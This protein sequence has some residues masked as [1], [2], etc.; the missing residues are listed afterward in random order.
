MS[1]ERLANVN[2]DFHWYFS[3]SDCYMSQV[4]CVS[5]VFSG[6]MNISTKLM[7]YGATGGPNLQLLKAEY[8]ESLRRCTAL[9]CRTDTITKNKGC[10]FQ[11]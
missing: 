10:S 2:Y 11:L 5:N 9:C 1:V 3:C 6:N 8:E 4:L 7:K